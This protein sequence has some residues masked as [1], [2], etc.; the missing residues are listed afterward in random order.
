MKL[1][2]DYN[3]TAAG[4]YPIVLVTYEIVCEKGNS[5]TAL[6]L[7]KGFLGYASSTAGQQAITGVGYAPLPDSVRTKVA[8]TVG[9]L[10]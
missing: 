7:I 1:K 9:N 6:P 10:G 2:I 8:T 3:T 4:A 5:S